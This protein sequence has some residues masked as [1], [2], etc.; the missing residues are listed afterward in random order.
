M[1]YSIKY[2][3]YKEFCTEIVNLINSLRDKPSLFVPFIQEYIQNFEDGCIT[4]EM[5]VSQNEVQEIQVELEEGLRIVSTNSQ[6]L[7]VLFS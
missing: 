6:K 2:I 4:I 7:N 3:K 5:Y 1:N